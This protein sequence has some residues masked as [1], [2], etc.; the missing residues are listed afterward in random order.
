M[1]ATI[2]QVAQRAGVSIATVSYVLNGTGT[3]TE[4]T[5]QRVLKAVEELNYEPSHAA[6]SLRS[7][8]YTFGLALPALPG[9]LA[10]PTLAEVLAGLAEA[11]GECGYTL[12]LATPSVDKSAAD[13]CLSLARSG[14]VDGLVLLDVE[15]DDERVRVLCAAGVPH[16]CAGQPPDGCDSPFVAVDAQRG[17]QV[18]VQHLLQLGHRQI[19]LIQLPSGLADSEPC[20]LGY[21][22]ALQAAGVA[23]APELVVEAGRNEEDGYQAMQELLALPEPP[24][25]VLAGSDELAFGAMHALYDAQLVVGQDVSLVG[26]DDVPLAAHMHPPLTTMRQPRRRLGAQLATMLIHTIEKRPSRYQGLTLDM[27]LMIRKSTGPVEPSD[28]TRSA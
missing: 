14:Q 9:R 25:A 5:R 17:A 20:Y 16:V 2:K 19:G 15:T 24:T 28:G 1:P 23:A 6:R 11:A 27:R 22:A 18:A 21:R 13:M 8:S 12:L 26:F 4:A 7:R 3:V 10:D